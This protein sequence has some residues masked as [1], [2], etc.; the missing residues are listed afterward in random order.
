MTAPAE[1][2]PKVSAIFLAVAGRGTKS[3]RRSFRTASGVISHRAARS[4]VPMPASF[5]S[6]IGFSVVLGTR[7]ALS[8]V[9]GM[10]DKIGVLSS[11]VK[12]GNIERDRNFS[13]YRPTRAI[14]SETRRSRVLL[15]TIASTGRRFPSL[16]NYG[17]YIDAAIERSRLS[18]AEVAGRVGVTDDAVRKWRRGE[19]VK[20]SNLE[21]LAEA[22]GVLVGDL[23][24]N[25]GGGAVSEMFKPIAAA[26]IGLDSDEVRDQILILASQAQMNANAILRRVGK[27]GISEVRS[28]VGQNS[29]EDDAPPIYGL[30]GGDDEVSSGD[31]NAR[32]GRHRNNTPKKGHRAP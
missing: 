32:P 7:F 28:N 9:V 4:D 25:S 22:L 1:A 23:L 30:P 29:I 18:N 6:R 13:V 11:V 5:K 14:L 17:P 20:L 21:R 3:N 26:M 19:G 16:L 8:I 12:R 2:H 31:M 15:L 10:R 24:P 27:R